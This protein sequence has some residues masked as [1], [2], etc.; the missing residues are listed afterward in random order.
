MGGLVISTMMGSLFPLVTTFFAGATGGGILYIWS[1]VKVGVLG[2]MFCL[3]FQKV[4]FDFDLKGKFLFCTKVAF[5]IKH[6]REF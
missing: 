2:N 3:D 6:M 4:K 5:Q 1:Q